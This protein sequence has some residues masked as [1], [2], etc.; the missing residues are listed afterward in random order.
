MPNVQKDKLIAWEVF[1][2]GTRKMGL[3]SADLPEIG[4]ITEELKGAGIAGTIDMP[5]PGQVESMELKLTWRVIAGDRSELL[6]QRT[7]NI[8]L[9]QANQHYDAGT[10]R[11]K[12]EPVVIDVRGIPKGSE[13]GSLEGASH[14]EATNTFECVYYKETVGGKVKTE[15]DKLN[16]ICVINGVDMLADVRSALGI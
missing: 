6:E 9:R 2:E 11:F 16:D 12:V 10:G 14:V 8:T 7:H 1:H 5:T 15:I 4:F 3:A 13:S